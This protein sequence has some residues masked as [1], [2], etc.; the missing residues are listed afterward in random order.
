MLPPIMKP[1]SPLKMQSLLTLQ[2][3][4]EQ[5]KTTVLPLFRFF[6]VILFDAWSGRIKFSILSLQPSGALFVTTLFISRF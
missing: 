6:K 3:A 5:F 4:P 2:S 1:R